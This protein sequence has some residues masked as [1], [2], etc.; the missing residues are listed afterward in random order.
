MKGPN[1]QLNNETE[2]PVSSPFFS[3]MTMKKLQTVIFQNF[4]AFYSK[5]YIDSY[6]F[7]PV[8]IKV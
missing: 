6:R 8:I 3:T 4:F 2:Q 5:G 1:K 7:V